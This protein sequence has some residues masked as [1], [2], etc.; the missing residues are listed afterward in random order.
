MVAVGSSLCSLVLWVRPAYHPPPHP[1]RH[2]TRAL[3]LE[4]LH[5]SSQQLQVPCVPAAFTEDGPGRAVRAGVLE[6]C[7]CGMVQSASG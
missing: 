4:C 6:V 7:F 5:V 3:P 1:P 2:P